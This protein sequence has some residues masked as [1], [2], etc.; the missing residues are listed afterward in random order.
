MATAVRQARAGGREALARA[1]GGE[2]EAQAHGG[3]ARDG[4]RDAQRDQPPKMVSSQAR[5]D[6]VALAMERGHSQR[7]VCELIDL[8]RS[9]LKYR[10]V[11]AERDVPAIAAMRRCSCARTTV[12]SS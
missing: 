10:S 2:C 5:R 8:P 12:R 1:G 4:H 9:M 3:R 7:Q 11:R 6:Q